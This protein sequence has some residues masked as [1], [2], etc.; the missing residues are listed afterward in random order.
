MMVMVVTVMEE[1]VEDEVEETSEEED[2]AMEM[3]EERLGV[4]VEAEH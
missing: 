1:K 4:S 2:L 3:V